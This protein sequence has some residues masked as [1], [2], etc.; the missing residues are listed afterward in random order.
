MLV[1]DLE[2]EILWMPSLDARY[3]KVRA[4]GSQIVLT[5]F[6][7]TAAQLNSVREAVCRLLEGRPFVCDIAVRPPHHRCISDDELNDAA[8]TVL[9]WTEGLDGCELTVKSCAGR[10]VLGGEACDARQRDIAEAAVRRMRNVVS[11]ENDIAIRIDQLVSKVTQSI[12]STM[13]VLFGGASSR[14]DVDARHG[15]VRLAGTVSN[16]SERTAAVRAAW[17]TAGVRWVVDSLTVRSSADPFAFQP[18]SLREEET[19]FED[20]GL[21]FPDAL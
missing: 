11:V 5:G 2:E 18:E 16:H 4:N 1:A 9:A 13:T 12:G 3:V 7:P 14:I 10:V 17:N 20:E 19:S 8:R 21:I 6:V 15:V